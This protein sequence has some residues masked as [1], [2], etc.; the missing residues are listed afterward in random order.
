MGKR[1]GGRAQDKWQEREVGVPWR[2]EPWN[3]A[4][5]MENILK[6]P[7]LHSGKY[8]KPLPST[9]E[10]GGKTYLQ[11]IKIASLHQMYLEG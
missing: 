11:E 7:P 8:Q 5:S 6:I 9:L 3:A 4:R 2:G 1:D 10:N